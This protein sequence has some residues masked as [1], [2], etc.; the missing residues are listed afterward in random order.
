MVAAAQTYDNPNCGIEAILSR[1]DS[2]QWSGTR[3]YAK[4]PAH[5]DRHRSLS[6]ALGREQQL[7]A[8]CHAG[9]SFSDVCKALGV[10]AKDFFPSG[11]NPLPAWLG[12]VGA[13]TGD[14]KIEAIYDYVDEEGKL[15]YQVVRFAGKSFRQRRPDATVWIWNLNGVRKVLYRLPELI[16]SPIEEPVLICE[17]E[18][19]VENLLT[20]GLVATSGPG[21]A[22]K[23][24]SEFGD[25][26]RGRDVVILPDNDEPGKAHAKLVFKALWG[27]AK[28]IRIV[29]LP[30][31]ADHGDVSDWLAQPHQDTVEELAALI[32]AS[33]ILET[34]AADEDDDHHHPAGTRPSTSARLVALARARFRLA[35]TPGGLAFGVPIDGPNVA[36]LLRGG[37]QSLRGV[38]AREFA[39]TTGRPP[40]SSA[41]AD[42]LTVLEAEALE[43]DPADLA[44]RVARSAGGVVLDLGWESGK[45]V[46]ITAEGWRFLGRS[47]VTF[48]RTELTSPL[49]EPV[50]GG[51]L[52][53]LWDLVNVAE[54]DRPQI[55]GWL[56]AALLPEIPHPA[57]LLLGMQG[58]AKSTTARSLV[59]L[60]DPSAAPLRS[61]PA[62]L[63]GWAV[64]AS[65][66]W[67]VALDNIS[68]I[69]DWLSDA[70]CRAVTGDGLVK[71]RLYSDDSLAILAFRRVLLL[72]GIDVGALRGDLADRLMLVELDPIPPEARRQDAELA[73]EFRARH[74]ALLGALLDLTAKVLAA[75]SG[76][77]LRVATRMAD[78]GHVL[79]AV[80]MVLGTGS[81]PRY[82]SQAAAIAEEV[83]AGDPVAEALLRLVLPGGEWRGT[84]TDLLEDLTPERPPRG[85]PGSSR[86]L[87]GHLRR[88]S[89]SL[90]QVGVVLTFNPGHR[91][92]RL[93]QIE[94]VAARPSPASSP[95]PP[96][97]DAPQSGDAKAPGGDAKLPG[98]DG[99]V[100]AFRVQGDAGDAGDAKFPTPSVDGVPA[101]P[102]L[103]FEP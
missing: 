22:G 94:R 92:G 24:Q 18:K 36:H 103:V 57:L 9:C 90:A 62:D 55:L 40:S 68:R 87:G 29:E 13:Q 82:A 75:L 98:G 91:G 51:S 6:L 54:G 80:D 38:L 35:C 15:L 52:G 5:D 10:E 69:S 32:A 3:G 47:P 48:R 86:A 76:I 65:G 63:D 95:S 49:P 41:L 81:L 84:A 11:S 89:P 23:W 39:K 33:P 93:I 2:L 44:L 77:R 61:L 59:S 7:L 73:A 42:A 102:P 31:L 14:E 83:V 12:R 79:A 17:G 78:Y 60:V 8:K 37:R 99:T 88:L 50:R 100:P 19:D 101:A 71:R 4:C 46:E 27:I 85:W 1:L 72:T 28:T 21:G 25:F 67:I 74:P 96:S 56:V 58:A 26:L 97:S 34:P 16:A 20:L 53:A 43:A 45:V 66:S 70:L 64:A 30:G